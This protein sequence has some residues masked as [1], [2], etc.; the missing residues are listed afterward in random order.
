MTATK[1]F[2]E[3]DMPISAELEEYRPGQDKIIQRIDVPLA[4]VR[5]VPGPTWQEA[6]WNYTEHISTLLW[7][8]ALIV[9][10]KFHERL[11]KFMRFLWGR[12][13]GTTF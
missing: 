1:S 4:V 8:L 7:T 9:E 10:Y 13:G 12:C 5:V 6:F 11:R 2:G 3:F